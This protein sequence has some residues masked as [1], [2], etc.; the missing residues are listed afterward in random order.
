MA[1]S[2]VSNIISGINYRTKRLF[3]NPFKKI[4]LNSFI[5][6]KIKHTANN[7]IQSIKFLDKKIFF[8]DGKEFLYGIKEIFVE[9]IYKVALPDNSLVLDCG[10]N[11][12]LSVIYFKKLNPSVKVIAF[13]P[14]TS[15]FELLKKNIESFGFSN[16]QLRK[17]AVWI[18]NT[19][20]IFKSD[21]NM[22]SKIV[23]SVNDAGSEIKVNAIRLKELITQPIEMLKIDIEGAEYQVLKD[24]K[25]QL[26]LIK[27]IFI[28][29][30]GSYSQNPELTEILQILTDSHFSYYI[31]E[32]AP[33][34]SSPFM[35]SKKENYPYDVQLNIFCFK[36]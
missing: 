24:I 2:F 6:K 14:D 21:G 30:H 13:E 28:E 35:K 3:S 26:S 16:L 12:G 32:A 9:E 4:G 15:N 27:N 1:S 23:T 18:E 17:E 11:I 7:K 5:V 20:L 36:N 22:G 29:Y 34:Y 33:I 10:A 25:D 19:Q 8:F 31:K